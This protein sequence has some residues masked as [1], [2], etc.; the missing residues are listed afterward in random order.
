LDIGQCARSL[1]ACGRVTGKLV[2]EQQDDI[3][4]VCILG[5]LPKARRSLPSDR[6]PAR[7]SR[8]KSKHL[9]RFVP[10][11]LQLQ[12]I[13]QEPLPA[14]RTDNLPQT[15]A[16]AGLYF[17]FGVPGQSVLKS[18]LAMSVTRRP[19]FR[20][21]FWVSTISF[22]SKLIMFLVPKCPHLY[23]SQIKLFRGNFP[24]RGPDPD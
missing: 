22:S 2:F 4:L 15:G 21:N 13:A 9:T 14:F 11:A 12:Q 6:G 7:Q 18:G 5:G 23:E 3:F 17:D 1:R 24:T 8:Q 20:N 10:K 16:Q 19:Y